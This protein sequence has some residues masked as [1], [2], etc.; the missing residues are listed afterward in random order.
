MKKQWFKILG[1]LS[2][3]CL[4]LLEQGCYWRS[5]KIFPNKTATIAPQITRIA[6]FPFKDSRTNKYSI[7]KFPAP[8]LELQEKI[9]A[10][11]SSNPRFQIIERQELEN[12]L[13]E[14]KLQTSGAVENETAVN[15][16]KVLGAQAILMGSI[17]QYGRHW[18]RLPFVKTLITFRL[19]EIESARVV[20]SKEVEANNVNMFYPFK[21]LSSSLNQSADAIAKVINESK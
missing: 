6:I 13:K 20:C 12:L 1:L 3:V 2:A 19:V 4:I 15:M 21:N 11:L 5:T 9:I 8:S 7:D 10:R 18:F 17:N 16:G 14:Q